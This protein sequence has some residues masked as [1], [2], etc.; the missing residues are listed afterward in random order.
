MKHEEILLKMKA[1]INKLNRLKKEYTY[2]ESI[3]F[4]LKD[5]ECVYNCIKNGGTLSDIEKVCS[6]HFAA[7]LNIN[8]PVGMSLKQ[9]IDN[10]SN[11]VETATDVS[12][13]IVCV[14]YNNS[15]YVYI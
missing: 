15:E 4:L 9:Y 2:H 8:I 7:Y 12:K 6:K 5:L 1:Q 13:H 11:N 3:N 10:V 14:N